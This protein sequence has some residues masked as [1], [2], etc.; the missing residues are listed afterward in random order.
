MGQHG[1]YEQHDTV[2]VVAGGPGEPPSA[3]Q[4]PAGAP[5]VAA[6]GGIDRALAL[7][8][9]VAVAVGDFDSVTAAGLTAVTAAGAR[10]EQHSP[11]KDATDLELALDAALAFGPRRIVVLG[12]DSGRL[13][14]LF[15]MLLLL[16]A[17]RYAEVEIDA[18]LGPARVHV[19]RGER[20]LEGAPG[21]LVSLFALHGP[22]T[23][24]TTEGLR[25]PLHGESLLAGSS[26]GVS[27]VF[28]AA[29]A[30]VSVESGVLLAVRPGDRVRE[31]SGQ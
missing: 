1:L 19:V 23:G 13:D 2:V 14:H 9:E 6:D 8:L 16:G 18:G 26:R 31:R 17:D 21:E 10:V 7:R 25:F 3:I 5:V 22:A 29:V 20:R 27:N 30:S 24:V 12:S 28:E 4:S 15:S 11:E